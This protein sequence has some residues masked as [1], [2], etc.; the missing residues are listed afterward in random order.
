M[1]GG[2]GGKQ[3]R[4]VAVLSAYPDVLRPPHPCLPILIPALFPTPRPPL[5]SPAGYSLTIF[6]PVSLVCVA[7][8][9]WLCW[10]LVALATANSGLFL[11]RSFKTTIYAAA[12]A[13]CGQPVTL[14]VSP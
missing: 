11:L 6:I 1:G 3:A 9:A 8:V 12:P 2:V 4:H 13:R 5:C 7:P 10:L 14:T